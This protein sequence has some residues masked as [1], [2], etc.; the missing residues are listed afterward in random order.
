MTRTLQSPRLVSKAIP[1]L[2]AL[3][4]A[5]LSVGCG[6]SE[7]EKEPIVS[8]QVESAQKG[9][10][11]Q[12][13][14][15]EAV[16]YPFQQAV[17]TPKITSTIREFRVHRGSRVQ[18]GQL[19]AILENADLSATAE[20][21]KGEF[22]QAEASYTTTT[23]ASLPQEIQKAELDAAAAKAAFDAQ[24]KVYD[25]RKELFQ[26]GAI[27][28]RD[29][30]AAE[31]A[32]AQART[33][34]EVTQRQLEDLR[35]VGRTQTLKSAQG[36]L[37][38]AKGK[39]LGAAAQ[40]S[41]SEIRSPIDG[42]VTERPQYAGELATA[43]QP[44]L[45]VMDT[46]TLIAKAH[47]PQSD[48]AQLKIGNQAQ[49]RVA[50]SQDPIPGKVTLVSPALDAGSTTI[51]VWVQSNKSNPALRPGMTAQ[52]VITARSAKDALTVPASSVYKSEDGGEFVLIA[53]SDNHAA[54]KTVQ[55]GIRGKERFQITSGINAGD[56]VITTGGYALPDKT[57]IKIEI[58]QPANEKAS[59]PQNSSGAEKE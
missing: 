45:T 34:S 27:P 14:S 43:N 6:S 56:K 10:I 30:D 8:V 19:L 21:S 32:L 26:Q 3:L 55:I 52:I 42:F 18:K 24:Q 58:P 23:V 13:V 25:S 22:E 20:Q 51:E 35:R 16:V 28:R 54:V 41:Y 12:I 40:L 57:Q 46:S 49:I 17:I 48:A 33:Q 50:G 4:F 38:A 36:Q 15:A 1:C 44:L 31:V 53:G 59:S 7:K 9:P 39:Y 47:I 5:I 37:T 29:F 11:E 2:A